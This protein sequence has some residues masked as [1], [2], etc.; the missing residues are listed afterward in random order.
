MSDRRAWTPEV[1]LFLRQV[2]GGQ[3]Y[4]Q[5]REKAWYK[6]VGCGRRKNDF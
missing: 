6:K 5:T 2:V 3:S 4:H 1:N